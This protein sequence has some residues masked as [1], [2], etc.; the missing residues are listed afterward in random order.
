MAL[1]MSMVV[2]AFVLISLAVYAV[3]GAALSDDVNDQL[4]SRA[5]LLIAS[6]SL[7][8][9]PG[10]AIEGTAYS[11]VNAMLINPGRS[12][13]STNQEGQTLP[14]GEQEKRVITGE[15]FMSRRTAGNQRVLAIHLSNGS[16]LLISK[17]LA[18][19]QAVMNRLRWVLLGVG[20]VGLVI[21]AIAGGAVT[22]TGLKPVGRLTRAAERVARTDDLRPIPVYGTDELARL[23]SS[24]NMMLRALAESRE[25]QARLVADAGHELKTPL[26]SLRTNVELLMA[27]H[28]PGAP[29]IAESD[30]VELRADV[31]AQIE[32]LSTLVGDLVD[33]ARDD[34]GGVV[35]DT[36]DVPELIDRCLERIRRRRN[37]VEFDVSVIP[38]QM[39]GD[40]AGLSRAVLNLLDNAAK[41]SPPG[42]R[43]TVDLHRYDAANAELVVADRGPGIPADERRL[44]FERFYRSDA[45][46]AMPGSGLG[47]AIVKQV[48]L[49]HGGALRVAETS[50]GAN[51]PGTSF[52]V[53]LPGEPG[54]PPA[55]VDEFD[56]DRDTVI[57]ATDEWIGNAHNE[58]HVESVAKPPG[59]PNVISVDSKQ[60]S[61]D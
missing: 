4:L 25:R 9:D 16:T 22:R 19:T 33:L 12:V 31:I 29:Q 39:F 27:A 54:L 37:D 38:W 47:L 24:F 44:V 11:D 52:Y 60:S 48:V 51:A 53:L 32:E 14:I 17:S 61:A 23:T 1:A 26:T 57:S 28:A 35:N 45:A 56:V 50:P 10:K 46:R 59:A 41:W 21:A 36:V 8:A 2:M 20:G 3:V 6:G 34:A 43:V 55:E 13:Y 7:A 40:S 49:K 15:L 58:K 5:Q 42:G 18:P 30:L